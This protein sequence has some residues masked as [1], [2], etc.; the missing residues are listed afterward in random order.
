M[1]SEILIGIVWIFIGVC[2][3]SF[4]GWVLSVYY[5][6]YIVYVLGIF[7][8]IVIFICICATAVIIEE[9]CEEPSNNTSLKTKGK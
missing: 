4:I 8:P 2:Y 6:P 5:D 9:L 3:D 7:I 1:K